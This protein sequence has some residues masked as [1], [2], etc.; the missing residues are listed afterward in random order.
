[1][2]EHKIP[3]PSMLYNAA[4]GGH[5]TNSQQ[6]I[7]ENENKEQS[8]INAEV[9][10]TL[11]QGG[12]VDTR[13]NQVKNDIIGN[14]SSNGNTLKKIEDRVSPL[15]SAIGSGGN[16]DARIADAVNIEKTRAEGAEQLLQEQYNAL[17][18]SDIEVG[19]LPASGT[20]NKIYRVPGTNTYSD[21]MWN[22]SSF[23]KMAEYDNAIDDEP[24]AGSDNLVKSGGIHSSNGG[25][26]NSEEFI[27]VE[28]DSKNRILSYID[29]N[30]KKHLSYPTNQDDNLQN[31]INN[32][33]NSFKTVKKDILKK[34]DIE[35]PETLNNGNNDYILSKV[36]NDG[37]LVYGIRKSD[38]KLVLPF[39][40]VLNDMVVEYNGVEY[41]LKMK[42]ENNVKYLILE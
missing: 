3:I 31:Q 7:D 13:I 1:M 35:Y 17:T 24:T 16:I 32:S 27:S 6:I 30:G 41:S 11:G 9:K 18:Q 15:E 21:Y 2:S 5:V 29:L 42:E 12:S 40:L 26:E 20:K 8:Q 19:A 38:G 14:A 36:D 34:L 28:T 4:V 23:V 37:R 39:G 33:S 25:Y 22:G 10:Q